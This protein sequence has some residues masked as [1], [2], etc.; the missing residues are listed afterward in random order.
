MKNKIKLG[1]KIAYALGD[2]GCNFIWTVVGSFLIMYYTDSVGI[3]SAVVGTIML[4]SRVLDGISDVGMGLVIDRTHTRWGKARPWVLFTAPLMAVGMILVFSVPSGLSDTGKIIYALVT[5]I[6]L[7]A[8]I[9][10]A[11]NL[12]YSTMLSLISD[13]QDDR[14]SMSSLRYIFVYV[15]MILL[16][17]I[18][19]PV[20]NACGWTGMA[21]IFGTAGMVCLLLTFFGTKERVTD[22][23]ET[24]DSSVSIRVSVG[25]LF[26]NRYFL[27]LTVMYVV[28]FIAMG[29]TSAVGIYFAKDY[30]GN[31]DL[32]G[33]LTLFNYIPVV[34][35]LF[36]FP[37]LADRLG[38]WKCMV[39]G[40]ILEMLGYAIVL[41]APTNIAV[42]FLGLIIRG[43][44][45]IPNTAGIFAMTADVA[46]Y[47]EWKTGVRNEG[48]VYS[49]TSF[50][51]KIGMG[52]GSAMVGWGLAF[53]KYVGT[54]TVQSAGALEAIKA[55]YT[56]VPLI[57]TAIG[58][59]ALL[60]ANL[61]KIYPKMREEL[62]ERRTGAKPPL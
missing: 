16:S 48:L 2:V 38:K 30:L 51:L 25:T 61:D 57:F 42:V 47:G 34:I 40:Y 18:T 59:I 36:I 17:Y 11:C 39:V 22:T 29:L 15:T 53:G 20:V 7:A 58:F 44:G 55:L 26:K 13:R 52:L 33:T 50:G 19:M 5:Y 37:Y 24:K 23:K 56:Y 10:T 28:N 3:A 32:F 31:T 49:S 9:Y 1:E 41:I 6:A 12:A 35:G 45:H 46:D 27:L 21:V 4:V 60:N 62:I 54:E 14:T 43:I 8:L